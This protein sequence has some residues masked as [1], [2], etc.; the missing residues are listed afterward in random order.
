MNKTT[1]PDKIFCI[2]ANTTSLAFS[3][4]THGKLYSYGKVTFEGSTL[5]DRIGDAVKKTK[6]L[7]DMIGMVDAVVI[8]QSVFMNS[9]KTLIDLSMIQGAIL[10][11]SAMSGITVFGTVPPITWQT[12]LGNKKLTKDEQL[13]IRNKT[14]GKSVAWYKNY[15]RNL[16]KERTMRLLEIIYDQKIEDNDVADACGIGHYAI[17]NWSKVVKVDK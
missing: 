1:S 17:N 9:P 6:A 4:Y 16:R 7:L 12:F 15:E 2:D 3:V 11:G 10:G 8:E 5:F 14:P 13:L